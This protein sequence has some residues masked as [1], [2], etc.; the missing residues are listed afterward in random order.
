MQQRSQLKQCRESASNADLK[1][2]WIRNTRNVV[3]L[4]PCWILPLH[5]PLRL[6]LTRKVHHWLPLR[7]AEALRVYHVSTY[8]MFPLGQLIPGTHD[9]V[10]FFNSPAEPFDKPN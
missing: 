10:Y 5:N 7:I 3:P 4:M 1:K 6:P 2:G 8:A 9:K